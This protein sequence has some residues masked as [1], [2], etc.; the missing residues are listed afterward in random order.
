ML[1]I[2][3]LS[4]NVFKQ[5]HTDVGIV[6]A[7]AVITFYFLLGMERS[8]Y[9]LGFICVPKFLTT[10]KITTAV[11]PAPKAEEI[12]C[13]IK[14]FGRYLSI[15]DFTNYKNTEFSFCSW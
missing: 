9:C 13:A 11:Y 14:G 8:S 5:N 2:I 4:V 7:N 1:E 15:F 12:K 6:M 10:L 3:H